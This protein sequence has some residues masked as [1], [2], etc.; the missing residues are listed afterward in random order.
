[1]FGE[2]LS[3][4]NFKN[5]RHIQILGSR[6]TMIKLFS[7]VV[8]RVSLADLPPLLLLAENFCFS[9]IFLLF[10]CPF[11]FFSVLSAFF[12]SFLLFSFFSAFLKILFFTFLNKVLMLTSQFLIIARDTSFN[13]N[14]FSLSHHLRL[15]FRIL[16]ISYWFRRITSH[17]SRS[18]SILYLTFVR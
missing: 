13:I 18:F 4:K 1:M 14:D 15:I 9:I 11:C 8:T 7:V 6:L 12:L 16:D 5:Q 10:F 17:L 2:K 3:K